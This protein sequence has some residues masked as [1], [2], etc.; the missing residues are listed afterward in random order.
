MSV[1]GS[2]GVT[3][4]SGNVS[5]VIDSIPLPGT[6]QDIIS[7]RGAGTGSNATAYTVTAGKKFYLLGFAFGGT[8]NDTGMIKTNADVEILQVRTLANDGHVHSLS[9]P[10]AVYTAGQNVR[11]KCAATSNYTI[12]GIEVDA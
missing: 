5:T 9:Y 11:V 3:Q 12:W 7:A 8:N 4:V 1:A 6:G 2:S 10:I